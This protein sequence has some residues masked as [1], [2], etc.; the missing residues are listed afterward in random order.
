LVLAAFTYL[1]Q[2]ANRNE[3]HKEMSRNSF[4]PQGFLQTSPNTSE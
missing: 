2:P 4:E 1:V 3:P